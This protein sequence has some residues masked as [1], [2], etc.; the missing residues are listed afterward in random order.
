MIFNDLSLYSIIVYFRTPPRAPSKESMKPFV[1]ADVEAYNNIPDSGSNKYKNI[2]DITR[3]PGLKIN[4][5]RMIK[6]LQS[7]I[8]N[9]GYFNIAFNGRY[10]QMTFA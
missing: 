1:Y 2:F 10:E 6:N 8:G 7:D 3:K 9:F 4:K 5:P